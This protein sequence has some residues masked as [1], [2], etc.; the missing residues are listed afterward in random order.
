[1]SVWNEIDVFT[2]AYVDAAL[3]AS[4]DEDQEPLDRN[5]SIDDIAPESME[6][7][8]AECKRFQEEN[9]DDIATIPYRR[10]SDGNW[11]GEEQ[12][13]HDFFLTRNRHGVGFWDRD[14][15]TE[16]VSD[17]LT[18]ASHKFGE[19]YLY[20]GDDNLIYCD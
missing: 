2:Q 17:R 5:Y 1:M 15:L 20:V 11:S 4:C 18:N 19:T 14:Y 13:G 12:A 6:K 10:T 9:A 7:I 3:W 16:E 8:V